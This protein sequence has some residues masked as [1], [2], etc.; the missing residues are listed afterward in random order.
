MLTKREGKINNLFFNPR[1]WHDKFLV[2]NFFISFTLVL[3]IWGAVIWALFSIK[4]T[5]FL[6]LH[7]SIYL[8][9]DWLG[10]PENFFVFTSIATVVFLLNFILSNIFYFKN[11]LLSYFLS[12]SA[13]IFLLALFA[14]VIIVI[15]INWSAPS[16]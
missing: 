2:C 4:E 14:S 11:K 3:A 10:G 13:T 7:Y 6:S 5:V 16:V 1:S 8:G 9:V 12:A 15:Y